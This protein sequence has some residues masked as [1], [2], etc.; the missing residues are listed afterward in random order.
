MSEN[1]RE[2]E[3]YFFFILR[4]RSAC[5][6]SLLKVMVSPILISKSVSQHIQIQLVKEYMIFISLKC[7]KN[8]TFPAC[9][10]CVCSFYGT[11][12]DRWCHLAVPAQRLI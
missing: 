5:V 11:W 8:E 1:H 7:N 4:S 9:N 10:M 12:N 2:G 3:T 6:P